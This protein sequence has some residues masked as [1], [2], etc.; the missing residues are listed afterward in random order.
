MHGTA[1]RIAFIVGSCLLASGVSRGDPLATKT[2][3]QEPDTARLTAARPSARRQ[4]LLS[5]RPPPRPLEELGEAS[6]KTAAGRRRRH[7]PGN[8]PPRAVIVDKIEVRIGLLRPGQFGGVDRPSQGIEVPELSRVG[9]RAT[10][11][12]ER[13]LAGGGGRGVAGGLQ[14][15]RCLERASGLHPQPGPNEDGHADRAAGDAEAEERHRPARGGRGEQDLL[16]TAAAAAHAS[17]DAVS[18]GARHFVG[19]MV[20][21]GSVQRRGSKPS[22]TFPAR[23]FCWI[24]QA[25]LLK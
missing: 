24:S 14:R 20:R 17:A 7:R 21:A 22:L 3:D 5:V 12:R 18:E 8:S 1:N 9:R 2:P 6:W 13:G 23:M 4:R 10:G 11:V 25:C 16:R 15:G 19:R